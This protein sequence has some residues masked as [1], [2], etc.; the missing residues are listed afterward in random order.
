[1]YLIYSNY[2]LSDKTKYTLIYKQR[3]IGDKNNK[4]ESGRKQFV[5]IAH[6]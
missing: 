4:M 6:G 3:N 1:M 5:G 2:K